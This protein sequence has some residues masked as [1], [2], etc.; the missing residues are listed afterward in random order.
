MVVDGAQMGGQSVDVNTLEQQLRCATAINDMAHVITQGSDASKIRETMVRIIGEALDVDRTLIYDIRFDTQVVEGLCEWLNPAAPGIEPTCATY[1]LSVFIGGAELARQTQRPIESQKDA[2]HPALLS[3]GSAEVLH[4]KMQIESLLWFPFDFEED[5]FFGLVFNQVRHRR[6]WNDSN[7]AF[8]QQV[9]ELVSMAHLRLRLEAQRREAE[10]ESERL[11]RFQALG[12]LAGGVAHDFNNLL[13]T[14]LA[15]AAHAAFQ[16][17]AEKTHRSLESIQ[18]A[19]NIAANMCKQLLTYSGRAQ[20]HM[21]LLDLNAIVRH[22]VGLLETSVTALT[23]FELAEEAVSVMGDRTQIQ[24][25]LLNLITNAHDAIA[26]HGRI[27]V[28]TGHLTAEQAASKARRKTC[29]ARGA[30]AFLSVEDN[31]AGMDEA[32]KARAFEPFFTSKSSGHGLGL[33]VV[34]G[35]LDNHNAGIGIESSPGQGT[36]FS[37]VFPMAEPK[38]RAPRDTST[39][40]ERSL[41]QEKTALV[42]DNEPMVRAVSESCLTLSGYHVLTAAS[43]EEALHVFRATTTTAIDAIVLDIT[44]PPQGGHHTL[45]ALRTAGCIAPIVLTG[46]SPLDHASAN[47]AP[48]RW[49][50]L[51]KPFLPEKLVAVLDNLLEDA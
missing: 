13:T 10:M 18:S 2:P 43:G 21:E 34:H 12:V 11:A 28:R 37:V 15:H 49:T 23:R 22:V 20:T 46:A 39:S 42:I 32:T 16:P 33:A 3:D 24:Q 8:V 48:G 31:G 30:Y 4:G 25:V 6:T 44:M 40:P 47:A 27:T 1:P 41:T 26:T 19:A 50:F 35:V 17:N 45:T 36:T 5:R 9:A 29:F 7:L 38:F 51:Q 14:I